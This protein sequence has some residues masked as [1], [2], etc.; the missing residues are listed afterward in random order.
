M[1]RD[2]NFELN[3]NEIIG[4]PSSATIGFQSGNGIDVTLIYYNDDIISSQ[5]SIFVSKASLSNWLM[6]GTQTGEMS[7]LIPGGQSFNI[8]VM[9]NTNGMDVGTY[10]SD[11]VISSDQVEPVAI[12]IE[13]QV[14]GESASVTVP[15]IDIDN[16]ETGIV[17]LPNSVDQIISSVF[18][19]YTHLQVSGQN[20][21][22]ILAQSEI[23][24]YQILH[25]KRILEEYLTNVPNTLW[26][27]NK[28][29]LSN[30]L[31]MSCLLYTSPSQRD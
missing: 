10:Y 20:V 5:Q 14:R 13:L 28:A 15:F 26:G 23:L 24:D 30:A 11:L 17:E 22:P 27:S 18:Q 4:S 21:I 9:A 16:S 29:A 12:P 31:S 8:S 7:G 25:V 19:K 1:Y 6:V 2:G 3:Y